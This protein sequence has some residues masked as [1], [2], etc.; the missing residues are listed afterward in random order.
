MAKGSFVDVVWVDV[1]AVVWVNVVVVA[2]SNPVNIEILC[3][4]NF[5]SFKL[6]PTIH[7]SQEFQTTTYGTFYSQR[8]TEQTN[9]KIKIQVAKSN[10]VII[11]TYCQQQLK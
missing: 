10:S 5:H 3:V 2:V 1:V 6:K 4:C 9:K 8:D 11:L 7:Q